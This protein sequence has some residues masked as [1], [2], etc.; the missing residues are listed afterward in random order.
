[1]CRVNKMYKIEDWVLDCVHLKTTT[2][3]SQALQFAISPLITAHFSVGFVVIKTSIQIPG[4]FNYM[5]NN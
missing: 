4:Y 2:K 3:V 1:M 5:S